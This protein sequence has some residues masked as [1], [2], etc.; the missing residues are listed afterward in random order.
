MRTTARPA[1]ELRDAIAE[2]DVTIP[3]DDPDRE[4]SPWP[5]ALQVV[6]LQSRPPRENPF[7]SPRGCSSAGLRRSD[8]TRTRRTCTR[9]LP[10]RTRMRCIG[11]SGAALRSRRRRSRRR[12]RFLTSMS[13][14]RA[15]MRSRNEKKLPSGKGS[16]GTHFS[17]RDAPP[18]RRAQSATPSS[19]APA[20]QPWAAPT[21]AHE[22]HRRAH[23]RAAHAR[24]R[25]HDPWFDFGRRHG[26]RAAEYR[27]FGVHASQR[28]AWDAHSD[29]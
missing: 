27:L 17:R 8:G 9:H 13:A 24:I 16:G 7:P 2:A 26:R 6:A 1:S 25:G 5:A 4:R 19:T 3:E 20:L 18:V 22:R 14:H 12:R 10:A 29:R 15:F 11:S 28:A 21:G 23:A